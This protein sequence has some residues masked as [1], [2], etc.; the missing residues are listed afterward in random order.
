M[1]LSKGTTVNPGIINKIDF[2]IHINLKWLFFGQFYF[3]FFF[4]TINEII[5]QRRKYHNLMFKI[6]FAWCSTLTRHLQYLFFF[7]QFARA[8]HQLCIN[9]HTF[10][11]HFMYRTKYILHEAPPKWQFKEYYGIFRFGQY[12][13]QY[14][15][16]MTYT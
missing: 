6:S 4:L 10:H 11:M 3:G 5:A 8:M 1:S 16:Q 7:A 2:C 9:L 15:T 14:K 13:C 12:S